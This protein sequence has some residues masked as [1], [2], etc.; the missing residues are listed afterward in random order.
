[1]DNIFFAGCWHNNATKRQ[2][3]NTKPNRANKPNRTCGCAERA[4]RAD[5]QTYRRTDVQNKTATTSRRVIQK[6]GHRWLCPCCIQRRTACAVQPTGVFCQPHPASTAYSSSPHNRFV[7]QYACH[8]ACHMPRLTLARPAPGQ[9][10]P[11]ACVPDNTPVTL[12]TYRTTGTLQHTAGTAHS[13]RIH[14]ARGIAPGTRCRTLRTR[15]TAEPCTP[16][17]TAPEPPHAPRRP[18]PAMFPVKHPFAC[19]LSFKN[20]PRSRCRSIHPAHCC[21]LRTAAQA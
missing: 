2:S 19:R 16:H 13:K 10:P 6:N 15:R 4:G 14:R 1:M 11:T 18:I 21:R 3:D 12:Y 8:T 9:A 17:S 7:A 20:V 5:I